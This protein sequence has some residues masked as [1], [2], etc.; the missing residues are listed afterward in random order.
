[1]T[2]H[3]NMA[4]CEKPPSPTETAEEAS[5]APMDCPETAAFDVKNSGPPAS[6]FLPA[7]FGDY[8]VLGK[9]AEGGMGVVY[10]ARQISLNRTVALK[11]IRHGEF[12]SAG[13]VERFR[14]E[15]EAAA[16]L[17]HPHIVAIHEIGTQPGRQY[18]S[19]QLVEGVSLALAL[20]EGRFL[21]RERESSRR[22]AQLLATVARAVHH[23]H[24]HGI[25]HRDLK[26]G[27]ILLDAQ[28]RPFVTDFG[29]AKRVEGDSALT[30]SG[31]I[32]GTASY[33]SP[34]QAGAVRKLTTA[35]DVYSLGAILYETLTG[36]PPHR[37]ASTLDTLVLVRQQEPARPKALNPGVDRD[38]ETICLKCLDKEP[39]RRYG[40]AEALAEDLERWLHYEP[41][42]ARR[43]SVWERGGKWVRRR[44]GVASLVALLLLLSAVGFATVTLL[45]QDAAQ[46]RDA[47]E[48]AESD[49]EQQRQVA[50]AAQGKAEEA[51]D[52][53][54]DA[55]KQ[56]QEQ[57][58]K[59]QQPLPR[60]APG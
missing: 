60:A 46:A 1:M 49:K 22:V 51:R 54:D 42:R 6:V 52:R 10:R 35:S 50:I 43:S 23:A 12:A 14:S 41:I 16:M 7:H 8:E 56:E 17:E 48:Q 58:R 4:P 11:M 33:M 47:A 53:A 25:L 2:E 57:R 5:L 18:F 32:V 24:Q 36:R 37:G 20:Q 21:A 39:E 34:E 15:A 44:P 13:E 40:S 27:N 19:M 59:F 9:I 30:Q 29:L 26:P 31:A 45:W 38:L 55:K 3:E 28:D